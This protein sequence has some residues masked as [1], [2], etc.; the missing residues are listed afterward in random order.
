MITKSDFDHIRW[1]SREPRILYWDPSEKEIVN[2]NCFEGD[3]EI[4]ITSAELD[5]Y[6]SEFKTKRGD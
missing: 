2:E 1:L 4:E 6:L 5:S 3:P